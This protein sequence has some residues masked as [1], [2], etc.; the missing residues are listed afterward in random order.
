MPQQLIWIGLRHQQPM[1]R[2]GSAGPGDA[3]Q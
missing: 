3:M 1:L 2:A